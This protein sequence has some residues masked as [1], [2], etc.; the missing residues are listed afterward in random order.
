ME[1]RSERHSADDVAHTC[2]LLANLT[3]L[4]C[5][6][7]SAFLVLKAFPAST[8]ILKFDL[9]AMH[10][11]VANEDRQV[12]KC[13]QRREPDRCASVQV[14]AGHNERRRLSHKFA[15]GFHFR[16][17]RLRD[18]HQVINLAIHLVDFNIDIPRWEKQRP[19][20]GEQ[21]QI[22]LFTGRPKSHTSSWF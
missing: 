10:F 7:A 11:H 2:Q 12:K 1:R 21:Q 5:N 19:T 3:N 16:L 20:H 22:H 17:N 13:R 18:F 9:R 15:D 4:T 8:L 6:F 14:G